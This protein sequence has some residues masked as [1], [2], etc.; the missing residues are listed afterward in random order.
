M[1]DDDKVVSLGTR[2][3]FKPHVPT[4][5]APAMNYDDQVLQW[6]R[7]TGAGGTTWKE[8]ATGMSM[9]HGQASGALSKLHRRGKIA[10]LTERRDRCKVYVHPDFVN[11]RDTDDERPYRLVDQLADVLSR[12]PEEALAK[13]DLD[14]RNERV[15]ALDL[16]FARR[17]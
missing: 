1:S 8:F 4:A 3:E 10:R 5:E 2:R 16:Y 15:E 13:A 11:G 7:G 9:H 6:I 14:W 17:C 12:L